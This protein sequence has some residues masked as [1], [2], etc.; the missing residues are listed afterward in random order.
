MNRSSHFEELGAECLIFTR[1]LIDT[2]PS[3]EVVTAYQRA[4]EVSAVAPPGG[5]GP[6]DRALLRVAHL[7]PG[8]ARAADGYAAAFAKR[9]LLRRKL[10]LLV[11]IL[12]S[13]Q[14]TAVVLDTAVPGSRAAWVFTTGFQIAG[15]ALVVGLATLVIV[16]LCLWYSLRNTD[17]SDESGVSPQASP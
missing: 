7:G 11:A 3:S 8:F 9:S 2:D 10:V 6:L 5:R 16:P 13:R 1:Y 17:A 4:H 14:H 15:C 12:E